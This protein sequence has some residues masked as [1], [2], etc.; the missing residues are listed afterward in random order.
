MIHRTHITQATLVTTLS[1]VERTHVI[2][3]PCLS[4]EHSK[5]RHQWNFFSSHKTNFQHL[6]CARDLEEGEKLLLN[7]E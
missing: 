2:R 7:A 5:N 1:H 4:Y 6:K 3:H